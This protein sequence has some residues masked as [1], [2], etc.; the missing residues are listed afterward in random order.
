MHTVVLINLAHCARSVW[1]TTQS[2]LYWPGTSNW[3]RCTRRHLHRH[4]RLPSTRTSICKTRLRAGFGTRRRTRFSTRRRTRFS[5]WR[6]TGR[7][8]GSGA[9]QR[10]G[11]DARS[12]ARRR[13]RSNTR[14]CTNET[15]PGRWRRQKLEYLPPIRLRFAAFSANN[16]QDVRAG[17]VF[18]TNTLDRDSP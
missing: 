11:P 18:L 15:P 16:C 6:S 12:G 4:L 5:T 14:Q 2:C 13:T 9:R 17:T 10:T 8:T 7:C 3:T 1:S